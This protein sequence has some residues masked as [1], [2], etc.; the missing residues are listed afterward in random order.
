MQR[1]RRANMDHSPAGAT[2]SPI[3]PDR[4]RNLRP[5]AVAGLVLAL[6]ASPLAWAGGDH[7]HAMSTRLLRCRAAWRVCRVTAVSELFELVGV[8]DGRRL[9][10]YLD[11]FTDD[12][13][14]V[15]NGRI[16]LELGAARYTPTADEGGDFSVTWRCARRRA[17]LPVTATVLAWRAVRSAGRVLIGGASGRSG[18]RRSGMTAGRLAGQTCNMLLNGL[19]GAGR[20]GAANREAA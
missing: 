5:L 9:T 2:G 1:E 3:S 12:C 17:A 4:L 11:R 7:D 13:S 16:E 10:L 6:L 18:P 14:P 15:T 8:L 20:V 19:T